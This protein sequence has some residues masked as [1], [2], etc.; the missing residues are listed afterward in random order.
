VGALIEGASEGL[1]VL[2]VFV[3]GLDNSMGRELKR[4]L[5]GRGAA[6]INVWWGEPVRA[7]TLHGSQEELAAQAH[8]LIQDL[9]YV[10]RD[11]QEANAQEM[12]A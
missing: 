3:E 11:A 4:A 6:P 9:A 8:A 1:Y 12:N 7:V 5:K 2:P 10:A